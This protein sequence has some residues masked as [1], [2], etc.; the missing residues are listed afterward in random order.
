MRATISH[1]TYEC[2]A[3]LYSSLP[4]TSSPLCS[5][6]LVEEAA[7]HHL[8]KDHAS[9][10]TGGEACPRPETIVIGIISAAVIIPAVVLVVDHLPLL[11]VLLMV[12]LLGDH[13]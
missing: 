12:Y 2:L 1:I 4:V 9:N 8:S 13:L 5:R 10:E 3:N 7:V 6:L 11:L